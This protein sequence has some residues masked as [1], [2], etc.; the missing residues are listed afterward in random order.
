MNQ[1]YENGNNYFPWPTP[2]NL[3]WIL[4]EDHLMKPLFDIVRDD[5]RFIKCFETLKASSREIR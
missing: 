1:T 4:W 3:C 5:E 2:R